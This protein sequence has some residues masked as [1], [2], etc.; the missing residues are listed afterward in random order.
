MAKS[1]IRDLHDSWEKEKLAKEAAVKPT[2][3]DH[4]ALGTELSLFTGDISSPGSPIFQPDGTHIFQK[5]QDFLRAQ[6][7]VFGFREVITPNLY[8]ESLWRRSGHWDNYKDAMFAVKGGADREG[9]DDAHY[10]LKPMNCPGH[11]L[12]F[13][14]QK[15]SYRELPIRYADFSPLHRNEV[16]GALSG[17][18]RV[19]RF[20]Q[21]DGHIFCT[22]EQVRQEIISTLRF[23]DMVYKT[24]G[25]G[26]YRLVLSTKPAKEFIGTDEA[27]KMAEEQL[28]DALD[29]SG[30]EWKLN[31]GD[32]AFYG[33]K[34]D[35]N[36][37][38][39]NGK[40]HQTATVQL[41]F[42]LP[43]RFELEFVGNKTNN[44]M[45]VPVMIHRAVLG[46]LER[47][48]AL[49]IERF[50]G[51]WPFWLSPRQIIVLSAGRQ[52]KVLKYAQTTANNLA[53]P[54][55]ATY[56]A[57]SKPLPLSVPHYIVDTDFSDE[58]LAKKIHSAKT[59]KY[60]IICIL[61]EKNLKAA[62]LDLDISG[63][64]K[65]KETI[66]V[67]DQVKPG[68]RSPVQGI[69][70]TLVRKLPG[71]SLDIEQTLRA[72]KLLNHRYL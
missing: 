44:E 72:F 20:H 6:Y 25:I 37:T 40:Q 18:T 34:I 27:W 56:I 62:T 8:K 28:K 11:C 50:Q 15:R 38:D 3:P 46:S 68:T 57:E 69:V 54:N 39:K 30:Q 29:K 58:T 2:D 31:A 52:E 66:E 24:L 23:V 12:L 5:L 19:R 4:R 35:I 64:P 65:Q 41:D 21:D 53:F 9:K 47:F 60:N 1:N 33:P 26:Q 71:L 36:L 67:F 17:L 14:S 13:K 48:M 16:S 49:L 61:G 55:T 63:Q 51:H 7:P 22:P 10:S 32:G 59:K 43:Q 42:Q 70:S 45:M